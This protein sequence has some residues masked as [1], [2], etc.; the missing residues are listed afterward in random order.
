M[1][2][3]HANG[4]TLCA[5]LYDFLPDLFPFQEHALLYATQETLEQTKSIQRQLAYIGATSTIG[6]IGAWRKWQSDEDSSDS[7]DLDTA[8]RL[9]HDLGFAFRAHNAHRTLI[10]RDGENLPAPFAAKILRGLAIDVHGVEHVPPT[11]WL[12]R[13]R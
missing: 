8:L 1:H 10:A 6:A 7:I 5:C 11:L 13:C 2:Q 4:R 12:R 9:L 3:A